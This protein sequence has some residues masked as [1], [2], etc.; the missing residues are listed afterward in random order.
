MTVLHEIALTTRRKLLESL[1]QPTWTISALATPLMYLLLF[2]PLLRSALNTDN[3]MDAFVPGMLVLMAFS[4]GM[5]AG[6]NAVWELE[7][8]VT[9]RL[10]AMPVSRCALLLGPVLRDVAVFI[11]AALIV[12]LIAAPFG[13]APV[14]PGFALAAAMLAMLTACISSCSIALGLMLR[15]ISSLAAVVTGLQL[16]LTLL[17]GI[18]LPLENGPAWLRL[19]AHIDPMYYATSASRALCGGSIASP[20]AITG[21]L[22]TAALAALSI[23]WSLH[24]QKTAVI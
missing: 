7:S 5:G 10:S 6:W 24:V 22:I 3:V 15:D 19:L 16:P 14:W 4:S 9:E 21:M 1:R 23:A 11:T 8:G 12:A 2:A 18:L 13:F 17:S 20:E